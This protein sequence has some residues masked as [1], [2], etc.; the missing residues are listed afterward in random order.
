[1]ATLP[2]FGPINTFGLCG[3][4]SFAALDYY[5][6][7]ATVPTHQAGDFGPGVTCPQAGSRLYQII[8]DRQMDTFNPLENPSIVKF[9]TQPAPIGRTAYEVTVQDEWPLIVAEIDAGRPCPIGLIANTSLTDC[10]QVVAVGYSSSPGKR[11]DIYDCNHPDLA[12][13]LV[14]DDATQQINESTGDTWIGL[15]LEEYTQRDVTYQDVVMAAPITTNPAPPS[16]G[17]PAEVGF[18][19]RNDGE[20]PA[21]VSSLDV[22]TRGPSSE[23]LD[24][25]FTSDGVS[26]TIAPTASHSYN[27][28]TEAFGTTSGDYELVAYFQTTQGDWIPAPSNASTPSTTAL[29]SVF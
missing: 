12:V 2:G 28:L 17:S 10:H 1:V 22:L 25:M 20:F 6:A 18:A 19:V 8:F 4:M 11:I 23:D 7:G 3:G 9:A 15:F 26:S 29:V 14:L 27:A 13:S 24:S 5:W 16:L 21:H